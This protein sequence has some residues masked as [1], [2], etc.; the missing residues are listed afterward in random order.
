M[1]STLAEQTTGEQQPGSLSAMQLSQ[2]NQAI[3]GLTGAQ[4]NW[5]SG[6]LAGIGN[7]QPALAQSQTSAQVTV[8]YASQTGNSRSVAEA[9]AE[10][11]EARGLNTRLVSVEEFKPRELTRE[12]LLLLVV[13]THGEGEPPE[14]AQ[15][16]YRFLNGKRAPRLGGLK[17]AVFG[18]GDSSYEHFCKAAQDLDKRLEELGANRILARVD[19]DLD[20]QTKSKNWVPN[21]L[22]KIDELVPSDPEK[23]V[24]LSHARHSRRHDR[25]NPFR[26]TLLE[27][28]RITT[29]SA[30]SDVRHIA[31]EIDPTTI[32]YAPG[33]AL[34]VWFRNDPALVDDVLRSTG[35]E[36]AATVSL[37]NK[38]LSLADALGSRLELT[39]LHPSVA[40]QWAKISGDKA[41]QQLAGDSNK[42]RE[43]CAGRQF[44]DLLSQHPG[45][46]DADA[47]TQLLQPLQPRLY[48]IASSQSEFEDEVHLTVAVLRYQAH[49]RNHLGGASG[50]LGERIEDGGSLD[51]YVAENRNF[52]LP[53]DGDMPIIMI[54]AGTGIAPY[55]GFLQQR[56]AQGATGDN[57][58]IFGNR[59]FHRDFLYQTDWLSQRK[60]GLLKRTTLAFSR[61]D[62]HRAYVQDRL[63]DQGEELYRWLQ[64]GARVYVCGGSPMEVGVRN[65]LALVAQ[66]QGAMQPDAA[67]EYVENLRTEGRYLRDVY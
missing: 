34:G 67:T 61:D 29:S 20:F 7:S 25:N 64:D 38:A 47:L 16:I 23:V 3:Q 66:A 13:S 19:A 58:L 45:R 32:S 1:H 6:Y 59:H 30:L 18:L 21:V 55:R 57:W 15:E 5:A 24:A 60:A 8:L 31:L 33:D 37:E 54:G 65:A 42:L 46:L 27:N 14:S 9:L 26:A 10:A 50:F 28:R 22:K 40:A 52:R 11:S 56:A 43:Y 12:K 17:Y 2:L 51:V 44:V 62:N 36:G 41:L 49:G 39:Q 48:S 4:L 35:L 63:L 53:E